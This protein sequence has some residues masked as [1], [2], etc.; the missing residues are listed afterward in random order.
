[1]GRDQRFLAWGGIGFVLAAL[2]LG[3]CSDSGG[4]AGP[5]STDEP[6]PAYLRTVDGSAAAGGLGSFCW[7]RTLGGTGVVTCQDAAGPVTNVN[8]VPVVAGSGLAFSFEAGAPA[9]TSVSWQRVSG[10]APAASR[11][12][13]LWL[14][15]LGGEVATGTQAPAA[16]GFYVVTA[17]AR[18]DGKGDAA[19]GWYVEVR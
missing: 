15:G 5:A 1:M 18:W 10:A 17:F 7:P 13:L 9:S 14:D 19:Y 8:P 16:A 6:P 4:S 11:G 2:V 3:A 12:R